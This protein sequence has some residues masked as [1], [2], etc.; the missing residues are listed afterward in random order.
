[1]TPKTVILDSSYLIMQFFTEAS[2]MSVCEYDLSGIIRGC[3]FALSDLEKFEKI[4]P[5]IADGEVRNSLGHDKRTRDH[6]IL[7]MAVC[8]LARGLQAHLIR[9]GTYNEAGTLGYFPIQE[10]N[11]EEFREIVLQRT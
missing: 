8:N 9:L 2:K 6:E 4:L 11:V 10:D 7:Y 5:L 1:M 3:F